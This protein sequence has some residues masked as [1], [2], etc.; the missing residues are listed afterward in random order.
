MPRKGKSVFNKHKVD[1]AEELWAL[2]D[3]LKVLDDLLRMKRTSGPGGRR[4]TRR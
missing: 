1:E 4:R 3:A 2:P